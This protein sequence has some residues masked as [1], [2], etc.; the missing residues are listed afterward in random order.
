MDTGCLG[1]YLSP[2]PHLG[3]MLPF[4]QKIHFILETVAAVYLE[5]EV[6]NLAGSSTCLGSWGFHS[7]WIY[8][9]KN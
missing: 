7:F 4:K 3:H 1:A 9:Y 6:V 2:C 5:E 8:C